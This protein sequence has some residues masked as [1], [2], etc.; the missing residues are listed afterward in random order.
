MLKM[1]RESKSLT[2]RYIRGLLSA[3]LT[4]SPVLSYAGP[5]GAAVQSGNI[6]ISQPDAASTLIQQGTH[7]GIIN[8]QDFSIGA[9]ESVQFQVPSAQAKTLN[10]VIGH[11]VSDIQGALSSNGQLYLVNPNGV[12]FG[13]GSRVDAAGLLVTTSNV[14]DEDF[15]NNF[16]NL[17]EASEGSA[18]VN[19]GDISIKDGG[20]ALLVA[21]QVVNNGTIIARFGK[22]GI[23]AGSKGT[24]DLYGDGLIQFEPSSD[25]ANLVNNGVI[26]GGYVELTA[27]D[28][29]ALLKGVVR[30][31]GFV[32]ADHVVIEGGENS[33]VRLNGSVIAQREAEQIGGRV[34]VLGDL[35]SLLEN[36]DIDV[37]GELGGGQVHVGGDYQGK[38]TLKTAT[39]TYMTAGAEIDASAIRMGDGGKVILWADGTTHFA[40]DIVATGGSDGGDGGFVETSGKGQL[41]YR[42]A[43]DVTAENGDIG[44]LL[45]DPENITISSD[46]FTPTDLAGGVYWFDPSAVGGVNTTGSNVTQINDLIPGVGGSNNATQG[47]AAL[48]AELVAAGLNGRDALDFD[49][50][51]GYDMA[52]N[53]SINTSGST[54]RII[55][56]AFR[57]GADVTSQQ[58]L[59][60][61]GGGSNGYGMYI[62]AG[63]L[64]V[65]GW[66]N[67]SG[68]WNNY[69]T[70]AVTPNTT[71]V[72]GLN[73][74][75]N[76]MS[77]WVNGDKFQTYNN[78][79]GQNAHS[80]GID[81]G[82]NGDTRDASGSLGACCNFLGQIGEVIQYNTAATDAE[83]QEVSQYLALQWGATLDSPGTDYTISLENLEA[84]LAGAN[85]TLQAEDNITID[86]IADDSLDLAMDGTGSFT[87]IADNDA[88]GVGTISMDASDAIVTQG[89]DITMTGAVIDVN[90]ITSNGGDVTLSATAALTADVINAGAG[91]IALTA[92]SNNDSAA[93][94]LTTS[95][96][97]ADGI[98]LTG[99]SDND[100]ILNLSGTISSG[101]G[102]L[103]LNN[104]ASGDL[105]NA[106]ID[107]NGQAFNSAINFT[108]SGAG[109]STIQT[110]GGDITHSGTFDGTEGLILNA[111]A[112]NIDL[113]GAAGGGTALTSLTATGSTIQ[114]DDVTTVW[115]QNYT[116]A[117]TT[118]GDLAATGAGNVRFV[119]N[120]TLGAD[121]NITTNTGDIDFGGTVDGGQA[122]VLNSTSGDLI[123]TGDFGGGA[124]LTS[125]NVGTANADLQEVTTTGGITVSGITTYND[126]LNAGGALN[127]SGTGTLA[128][129]TVFQSTGGGIVTLGGTLNGAQNLTVTTGGLLNQ[130]ATIG[131]GTR[132]TSLTLNGANTQLT[133]DIYTANALSFGLNTNLGARVDSLD[134]VIFN[135][136]LTLAGASTVVGANG[137]TFNDTVNGAQDLTVESS[138]GDISFAGNVGNSSA[139][140]TLTITDT[141]NL[142]FGA[143]VTLAAL[144]QQA[145]RATTSLGSNFNSTGNVDILGVNINGDIL[146]AGDVMFNV[147]G[148]VTGQLF[149]NSF[150]LQAENSDQ[151]G[152]VNS[153]G[154][155]DA[156][157]EIQFTQFG[158][159]PHLF[160]GFILP[161]ETIIQATSTGY[162]TT[163]INRA[164]RSLS[165]GFVRTISDLPDLEI[166]KS[167]GR[168]R[169]SRI[170]P[171]DA[172]FAKLALGSDNSLVVNPF[173]MD[174]RSVDIEPGTELFY[175]PYP[176][177]EKSVWNWLSYRD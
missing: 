119:N 165:G 40:G 12:I 177:L 33:I 9:G 104:F 71:Y 170:A 142:T 1:L 58:Y 84:Q 78:T 42:G 94:A 147:T 23:G 126:D 134:T 150:A 167:A 85:I 61:Q 174:F 164:G 21:P 16:L 89:G 139:L 137:I 176:Y 70:T 53:A 34:D 107:T 118:N 106:T 123:T 112:G 29:D 45:L 91:N 4:F 144:D 13:A 68:S 22:V 48:Q 149:A 38:G 54:D 28:V 113:S 87:L 32:S 79:N 173:L 133:G 129:D 46:P 66:R 77:A 151:T 51:D 154:G 3:V 148:S 36:T 35:V 65:A 5:T 56:I 166:L 122:L 86:D 116:G 152:E 120:V 162:E 14:S 30:V 52:N 101:A 20:F 156:L 75:N 39:T 111:G 102:G 124:A 74:D 138:A 50:A 43:V 153:I 163:Q 49:G 7:K 83:M 63:Q 10:R 62:E 11:N 175:N 31:N 169:V 155:L 97:T 159:G 158:A 131:G 172:S 15:L 130:G 17:Q 100:D 25:V 128:A 57:T 80:G 95:D 121:T 88:D 146:S 8:W 19:N 132:L 93:V 72:A 160:N 135:N 115:H 64:V 90:N 161:Y 96:L 37:S 24:I 55:L 114:L 41:A 141:G 117:T 157:K 171:T 81:L 136:A 143:D 105:D 76:T 98:T 108:L 82:R 47:S 99:G 125:L 27:A 103:S 67:S 145:G 26:R 109:V 127:L 110:G 18:I 59:Y 73:L 6:I 140:N 60:E 69:A 44:S 92:D 2:A 168:A